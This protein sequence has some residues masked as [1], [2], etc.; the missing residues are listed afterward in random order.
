[1]TATRGDDAWREADRHQ[2]AL[3]RALRKRRG[4]W[5]S[6]PGLALPTARRALQPLDDGRPLRVCDPAVGGG[7]FLLAAQEALQRSAAEL[8]GLDLDAEAVGIAR[9]SLPGAEL[10]VGDGLVELEPES[11]DAVLTNPPWETLQDGPEA[12]DQ[13]RALRPRFAHQ[14][15]GKLFTYR[16]FLERAYQLLRPGGRLGIVVP[17]GLW[18]DRDAAPLRELLLDRCSWEWLF[19]FENRERIFDIDSRYRFGVVIATKGGET[20]RVRAAFGRTALSDWQAEAPT[21]IEYARQTMRALSPHAGTIVEVESNRD[22]EL[23]TRMRSSGE[24]LTGPSG[25]LSWRQGDFNMTSDRARFMR[26]DVAEADGY[27]G[28]RDGVWR[29]EGKPDL[30]PLRQGAMIYDLDANAGAHDRGVGHKTRWRRPRSA[31]ELRPLYLVDA[32]AWRNDATARGPARIALRALSNATNERTSIACLLPDVPCG[33]SIGVLQPARATASPVCDLAAYAAVL[34]SLPFDWSLRMRMA[35]TNLNR[36][37]LTDCVLPRLSDP[38]RDELAVLALQLCATAPWTAVLWEHAAE[39]GWC[40]LHAPATDG[41]LRRAK[42]TRIDLL[43]G[44][45]YGLTHADVE[46]ITRGEPFAKG[47]WRVERDLDP[48]ARRPARWR[49]AASDDG[50]GAY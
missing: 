25:Q 41:A 26:R 1:M 39:E 24:S 4:A 6:P 8:V 40:K 49:R 36:F 9:R 23:L 12:G 2:R 17:A 14:G 3:P 21:H 45:A 31:G 16:L 27:S 10:H 33:N 47:F 35:G 43:V 37:V 18:F 28:D 20:A 48:A 7:S 38:E 29:S 42:Q 34:S 30:L 32:A 22:L 19:G 44:R 13:V 11:F 46:W 50:G 15:K 5:F